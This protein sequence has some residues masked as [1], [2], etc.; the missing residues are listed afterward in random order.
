M[1]PNHFQR[2]FNLHWRPIF[3]IVDA[4]P[5]LHW[6]DD[7]ANNLNDLF[8]RALEFLKTRVEYVQK[9]TQLNWSYQRGQSMYAVQVL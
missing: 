9:Q 5:G 1:S 4:F 7:P 8:D 6:L 3:E 2:D